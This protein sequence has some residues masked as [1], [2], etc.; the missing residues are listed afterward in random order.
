MRIVHLGYSIKNVFPAD[1]VLTGRY[2]DDVFRLIRPDILIEWN[3][4]RI[5]IVFVLIDTLIV[6]IVELDS[7]LWS[8]HCICH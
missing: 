2:L 8:T 6:L 7:F 5:N 3:R 1:T 4:V